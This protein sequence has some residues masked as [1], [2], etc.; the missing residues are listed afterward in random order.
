MAHPTLFSLTGCITIEEG[1][2]RNGFLDSVRNAYP[3]AARHSST[4]EALRNLR[5]CAPGERV[6]VGHGR[7][8]MILT[9]N[10]DQ[11]GRAGERI[12]IATSLTELR[13]AGVLRLVSCNTADG[14]I[15]IQ[16]LE[17]IAADIQG[18]V[19]AAS[20]LV[21]WGIPSRGEE[22]LYLDIGAR[23]RSATFQPAN[24]PI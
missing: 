24:A 9:S 18:T 5:T 16:F 14:P 7:P 20:G 4:E 19:I 6:I 1:T 15:G 2:D 11:I 23:W 12:T 22:G 8:G 3:H 13:G 17:K 10:G 21:R